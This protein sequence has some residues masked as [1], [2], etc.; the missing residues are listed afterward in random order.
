MICKQAQEDLVGCW[1]CADELSSEILSHLE[2]C[3]QC[4]H[5]AL[6]LRETQVML[7][8]L[9]VER[10]PEGL[11]AQIMDRLPHE[12]QQAGWG[13]R[14][15]R[16]LVPERRMQWGRAAALGAALAI[17]IAG[18]VY[19]YGQ[20][21][22]T[23]LQ[24]QVVATTPASETGG[25]ERLAITDAELDELILKHQML[26]MSQPLADDVGVGLVVYT[27]R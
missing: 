27:S 25:D 20:E 2:E 5:E 24:E 16:W 15:A 8:S 6:L 22:Q 7:H 23:P 14:I 3:E 12:G 9:P 26:E 4:R 17:A 13:E 19:W 1:G 18:G 11:T 21:Q 10:A